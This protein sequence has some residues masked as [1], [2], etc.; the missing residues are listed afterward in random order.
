MSFLYKDLINGWCNFYPFVTT[1]TLIV[2]NTEEHNLGPDFFTATLKR[3]R[4]AKRN[5]KI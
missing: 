1:F 5:L 2:E 4:K 3:E